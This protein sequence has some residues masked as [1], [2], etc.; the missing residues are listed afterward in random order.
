MARSKAKPKSFTAKV[1]IAT[2]LV[3][4]TF[5][6]FFR[7]SITQSDLEGK[8]SERYREA[9]ETAAHVIDPKGELFYE[10]LEF[11]S[12]DP[13]IPSGIVFIPRTG[14]EK[15][16]QKNKETIC[17]SLNLV[18]E[19]KGATTRLGAPRAFDI[20]ASGKFTAHFYPLRGKRTRNLWQKAFDMALY[21][22]HFEM[23]KARQ[24]EKKML[25]NKLREA[26]TN[27]PAPKEEPQEKPYRPR[28][29]GVQTR[30]WPFNRPVARSNPGRR[31]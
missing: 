20:E 16:F 5:M 15:E 8:E 7:A 13:R 11:I 28:G 1:G 22:R 10:T 12:K 2:A 14:A 29:V 31:R 17:E 4:A 18:L 23:L 9:I 6:P 26:P 21:E 19:I 3:G 30:A 25:P 27:T 24:K